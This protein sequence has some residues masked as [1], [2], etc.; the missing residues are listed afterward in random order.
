[1]NEKSVNYYL[2]FKSK[3]YL[4]LWF[5]CDELLFENANVVHF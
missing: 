2:G 3:R 5:I 4:E 1:M